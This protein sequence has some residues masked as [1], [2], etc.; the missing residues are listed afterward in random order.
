MRTKEGWLPYSGRKGRSSLGR[1]PERLKYLSRPLPRL[2]PPLLFPTLEGFFNPSL[3]RESPQP[4]ILFSFSTHIL[5]HLLASCGRFHHLPTHLRHLLG[6]HNKYPTAAF[7]KNP[8]RSVHLCSLLE[9]LLHIPA[10]SSTIHHTNLVQS[11]FSTTPP[12]NASCSAL[13]TWF[14]GYSSF[15][16]QTLHSYYLY[17]RTLLQLLLPTLFRLS[18]SA[19]LSRHLILTFTSFPQYLNIRLAEL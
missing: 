15:A 1:Q 12:A 5:G 8:T 11:T 16:C 6:H 9:Y 10:T 2:A 14:L 3:R 17:H 19:H 13:W 18:D 4:L 7:P